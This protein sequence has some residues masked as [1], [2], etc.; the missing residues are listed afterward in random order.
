MTTVLVAFERT[1]TQSLA[2]SPWVEDPRAEAARW[3]ELGADGAVIVAR[4]TDDVDRLVAA[5]ERR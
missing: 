3:A 2:G 4:T 1:P 5:A